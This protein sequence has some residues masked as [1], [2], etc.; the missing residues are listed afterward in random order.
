[1]NG[2][3]VSRLSERLESFRQS[4][5]ER[6]ALVAEVI[7]AYE[8]LK[9]K[10]SEQ[11]DD[12]DNEKKSRRFWQNRVSTLE[13]SLTD[14][15]KSSLKQKQNNFVVALI[16]GDGALVSYSDSKLNVITIELFSNGK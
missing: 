1:M 12:Y 5:A 15:E 11:Q 10:F 3:V 8:D 13:Q 16:D 7:T 2:A 9:L 14:L 6:D 4:D